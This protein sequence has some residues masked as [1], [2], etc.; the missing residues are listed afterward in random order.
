MA[1]LA[2]VFW[3]A[4]VFGSETDLLGRNKLCHAVKVP[5]TRRERVTK[6]AGLA[7]WLSPACR[8]ACC[9]VRGLCEISILRT[10]VFAYSADLRLHPLFEE[11]EDRQRIR[12][13]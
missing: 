9:A 8:L 6:P 2:R 12:G 4:R 11:W 1:M 7:A 5:P 3:R 13:L 10:R